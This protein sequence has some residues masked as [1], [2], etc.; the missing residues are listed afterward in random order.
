MRETSNST[1]VVFQS[2]A[3]QSNVSSGVAVWA[4]VAVAATFVEAIYRLGIR[5]LDTIEAGLTLEQWGWL[6]S[7][8]VG[9]T[10][11]EGYRALQQRFIPRVVERAFS[12]EGSGNRTQKMFAPLFALSLIGAERWVLI[13]AWFSVALII[14]AVF[15]VRS[16]P[17]PWRGI[18]DAAVAMA[19]LW[20]LVALGVQFV[21]A[22]R[23]S[24]T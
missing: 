2:H 21:A 3:A 1:A 13:R 18:I 20:G 24:K 23:A 11:V 10:Y 17:T 16:L 15:I 12:L 7:A 4:A 9:L 6:V 22:R 19:L 5:A 8:M 14:G